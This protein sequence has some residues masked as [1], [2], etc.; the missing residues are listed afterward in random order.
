MSNRQDFKKASKL[1]KSLLERTRDGKV[2]W[3]VLDDQQFIYSTPQG[4]T[5]VISSSANE[6][7]FKSHDGHGYNLL[8]VSTQRYKELWD[9]EDGEAP[10]VEVLPELYDLARRNALKVNQ[11]V[12]EVS[13]YLDSL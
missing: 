3:A 9:M 8:A 6:L 10:L 2:D 7:G 13:K 11:K 4:I 12:S 1:A 5:F